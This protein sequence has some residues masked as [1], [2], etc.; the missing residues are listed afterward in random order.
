MKDYKKGGKI[1]GKLL[2]EG[3]L[4]LTDNLEVEEEIEVTGYIDCAGY[5]IKAGDW[6]DPEIGEKGNADECMS[7]KFNLTPE[8][9]EGLEIES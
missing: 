2:I 3:N 6:I 8:E 9:Y 4:I 5:S 7:W 1:T